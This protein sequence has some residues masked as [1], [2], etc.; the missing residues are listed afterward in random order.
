MEANK[1]HIALRNGLRRKLHLNL[2][3]TGIE[4]PENP[5]VENECALHAALLLGHEW[6]EVILSGEW[7]RAVREGLIS[8]QQLQAHEKAM[9]MAIIREVD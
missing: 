6:I 2:G 9:R 7:E 4:E 5:I 8:P 1:W 3:L